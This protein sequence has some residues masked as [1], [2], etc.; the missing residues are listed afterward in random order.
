MRYYDDDAP[1]TV[2]AHRTVVTTRKPHKCDGC[3]YVLPTSSRAVKEWV[4][5]TDDDKPHGSYTCVALYFHAT[6]LA[7][8]IK[9]KEQYDATH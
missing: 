8:T 1:K 4:M 9:A 7:D 2:F 6:C 5:T 3:A